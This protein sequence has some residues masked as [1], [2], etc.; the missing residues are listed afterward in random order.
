MGLGRSRGG[1]S[2]KTLAAGD[3]L[4]NPARLVSSPGQLNDIAFAHELV[5]GFAADVTITDKGYDLDHLC[6]KIA[7]T[8]GE[9][10]IPPKRNRIVKL[11]TIPISIKSATSSNASSTSSTSSDATRRDAT[12][13]SS[14][15]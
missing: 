13:C 7:R 8:G 3:A 2:T 9:V 1:S 10:I 12:S 15:S 6:E 11:P 4:G 5:E 14:T